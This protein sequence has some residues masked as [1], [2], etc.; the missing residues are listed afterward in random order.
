MNP[1]RAAIRPWM[2][3]MRAT[4]TV[5]LI[6]YLSREVMII[7]IFG[8]EVGFEV[9]SKSSCLCKYPR[10]YGP[11]GV[12]V[13]FFLYDSGVRRRSR[14]IVLQMQRIKPIV[15]INMFFLLTG[16]TFC[17]QAA[18]VYVC[19]PRWGP[20][21]PLAGQGADVLDSRLVAWAGTVS[22]LSCNTLYCTW[23]HYVALYMQSV[24][25]V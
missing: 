7:R 3:Y 22:M 11:R 20:S 14:W 10:K 5:R 18:R 16:C 13:P 25:I 15:F 24:L 4:C 1:T 21:S 6:T 23:P 19:Q 2:W 17:K 12:E 8:P 9:Y